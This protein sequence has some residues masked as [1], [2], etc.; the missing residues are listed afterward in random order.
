[1]KKTIVLAIALTII[2][3]LSINAFAT[4]SSSSAPASSSVPAPTTIPATGV[5]QEVVD[6][7][8]LTTEVKGKI[9]ATS[10]KVTVPTTINFDLD[11]T[12]NLE[13]A[14]AGNNQVTNTTFPSITNHSPVPVYVQVTNVAADDT[15]TLINEAPFESE[16]W[17]VKNVMFSISD[18]ALGYTIL[19]LPEK[20]LMET[21]TT[22]GT[23]PASKFFVNANKGMISP[24]GGTTPLQIFAA[25][26]TGWNADELFT[27][28]PTFTIYTTEPT[29]PTV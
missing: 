16:A 19:E 3:S 17:G 9:L 23:T 21:G 4:A 20:L 6:G 28:T 5:E 26:R 1:M 7:Q 10:I 22:G 8:G 15:I 13:G 27:I 2:S 24:R 12:K 14:T 25:T 18:T 29:L 11:I